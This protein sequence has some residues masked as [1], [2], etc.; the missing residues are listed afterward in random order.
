MRVDEGYR[1]TQEQFIKQLRINGRS[2]WRSPSARILCAFWLFEICMPTETMKLRAVT[3][4]VAKPFKATSARPGR[5]H[6]GHESRAPR[7]AATPRRSRR[8]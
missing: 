8:S 5:G 1:P 3:L 4:L 7:T 6:T 2:P